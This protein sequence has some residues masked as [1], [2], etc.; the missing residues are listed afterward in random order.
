MLTQIGG[1]PE[2]DFSEP[3]G[4]L[5][6][7]H[8]RIRF[9]LGNL[10]RLAENGSH[11]PLDAGRRSVLEHALQ[12]FREG[13]PRHTLD[14]EDS[15]FPRLRALKHRRVDEILARIDAMEADHRRAESAHATVDAIGV[16]WLEDGVLYREDAARL[17]PLLKDLT[18]MY[19]RHL[20]VE[21]RE[22][23]P[24]AGEL[25]S[26]RDLTEIGREMAKRRG[27]SPEIVGH[28]RTSGAF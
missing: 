16:C 27:L 17:K 1:K 9:F 24:V 23:F 3:L 14:E 4:M 15:L 10:V 21:D 19:E 13:G 7:C 18:G 25:L 12:Y 11:K 20:A 8:K 2:S 6:D 5:G 22:I 28:Q 26:E